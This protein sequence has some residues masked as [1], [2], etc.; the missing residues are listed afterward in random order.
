MKRPL[1][2]HVHNVYALDSQ[3]NE[4][5]YIVGVQCCTGL[6]HLDF[7]SIH[8]CVDVLCRILSVE[9]FL[10]L[11][12]ELHGLGGIERRNDLLSCVVSN[13]PEEQGAK[14]SLLSVDLGGDYTLLLVNLK[15]EP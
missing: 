2:L 7:L 1:G 15:L 12:V 13:G 11:V 8:R 4:G 5:V 9:G 10:G 14:D 3:A 6:E